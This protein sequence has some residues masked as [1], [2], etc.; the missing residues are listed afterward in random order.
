MKKFLRIFPFFLIFIVI[1]G[2]QTYWETTAKNQPFLDPY[3]RAVKVGTMTPNRPVE[4]IGEHRF[5]YLSEK[6]LVLATL[7]PATQSTTEE[8]RPIP[9]DDIF[10]YTNY[11]LLGDDLFWIGKGQTLKWAKWQGSAWSQPQEITK[12]ATALQLQAVAG[13]TLLTVGREGDLRVYDVS[14]NTPNLLK[15]Y[16]LKKVTNVTAAL[17]DQGI[18]HIGAVDQLSGEMYHLSYMTL[19]TKTWQGAD[20]IVLRELSMSTDTSIDSSTFGVDKTHGY[21]LTTIKIG[22]L[23]SKTLNVYSFPLTHPT[24]VQQSAV[25]TNTMMGHE[26]KGVYGATLAQ[27]QGDDGLKFAFVANYAISPRVGGYEVFI[28]SLQNGV[29]NQ[30]AAQVSN[31]QKVALNPVVQYNGQ[32]LTAIFTEETTYDTFDIFANTNNPQYAAASNKLTSTDLKQAAG[33]VPLYFGVVIV[34]VFVALA[35][36]C[37]SYIYLMYFIIKKEDELYDNAS[38]HFWV[39]VLLYLAS[40][41]FIFVSYSN[42]DNFRV[43]AP[44]WLQSNF[45]IVMLFLCFALVCYLFT[46]MFRKLIYER[47]A[48]LEFS[49]FMGLNV[50]LSLLGISYWM[51][52]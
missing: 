31:I 11:K 8:K 9:A 10:A 34:Q 14:A 18:Y 29:W 16:P 41:I 48:I 46:L 35:W 23:G 52:Y 47:N 25:V 27:E 26:A 12:Q 43:Y 15:S 24:E 51:A 39:A 49:Y 4:W 37:I 21:F 30:D 44:E 13:K 45:A 33:Q 36:P 28:G 38:R 2:L 22:K 20:P 17:D 32:E 42:L 3:G 5:A 6:S 40:Q 50:W 19:D 7:D 1:F